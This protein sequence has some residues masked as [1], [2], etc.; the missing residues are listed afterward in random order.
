[1][2]RPELLNPLTSLQ[3]KAVLEAAEELQRAGF[4]C[5]LVG[6]CV[7]DLL[8]GRPVK[9][10]DLTS[11]A[12]PEQSR[13]LFRKTIPTGIE[14][15]TIT[16]RLHGQSLELTTYRTEGTYSDG[17]HPDEVRFG[18]S[19][20]EDLSR[21]D[22]TVNAL[23]YDPLSETLVDEHAGLED[24]NA[25]LIRTIGQPEDRFFEDGLR[26]I[27]ACRF[28]S[29]LGFRLEAAT[30]QAMTNPEVQKRTALVAIERFTDEL[31][32]GMK[33]ADPTAM[34]IGLQDTGLLA[35]FL[36]ESLSSPQ[37]APSAH[38]ILALK[39]S[40][41]KNPETFRE[42]SYP[43]DGKKPEDDPVERYRRQCPADANALD[44]LVDIR[45]YF[46]LSAIFSSEPEEEKELLLRTW[47]FPNHT[48]ICFQ[49]CA[50]LLEFWNES[51]KPSRNH[52]AYSNRKRLFQL[53][54]ILDHRLSDFLQC[55]RSALQVFPA[56]HPD[57]PS[58]VDALVVTY[59]ND[60]F[61]IKDLEISGRDLMQLGFQGPAIGSALQHCL[62]EVWKDPSR[63]EKQWLIS[64]A[65]DLFHDSP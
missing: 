17:R 44:W 33:A 30:E 3:R 13:K 26:P 1:M 40:Y 58:F 41:Q 28:L 7:R 38:E 56:P 46:W 2:H 51:M 36:P 59:E 52:S 32:K 19:L 11:N 21:R 45:M 55:L 61:R 18:Q 15:G 25:G 16:V 5:Y 60:P 14:H 47:K 49:A 4:E 48:L 31:R 53:S 8:L 35:L 42:D 37:P 34:L 29:T 64:R 20:I 62:E 12:L 10:L 54:R 6:G 43:G 27:R 24:L 63:N 23:A 9:D 65:K 57:L 22:F 50:N 39:G